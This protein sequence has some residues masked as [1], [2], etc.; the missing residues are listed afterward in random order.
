MKVFHCDHCD[1]L[2]FFENTHCIACGNRLAYLPE[3]SRIG[4]LD[5]AEELQW[6]CPASDAEG[7]RWRLCA[8]YTEHDVCNWAVAADDPELLCLSCRLT[9]VIPDLDKPNQKLWW[10]RLEM[11]KRRLLYALLALKLPVRSKEEDPD[12]GVAFEFRA[13]PEDPEEPPVLTGHAAGVITINVAEADDAERER[14]RVLLHEPYR[15]LLGHVRHEV[16]HYFWDRLIR[17]DDDRLAGFR[18]LFGDER[19][20]YAEALK[21]HYDHGPAEDWPDRCVTA[22]ASVHPWEDWAETWAH[23]LHITDTVEIA[24][25]SGL[26]LRPRQRNRL[27]LASVPDPVAGEAAGFDRMMESWY[28]LTYI[29]NNL[30]RGLGLP[31]AYPFV[32]PGPAIEKLRF[33]HDVIG[34]A[35]RSCPYHVDRPDSGLVIVNAVRWL[36][37]GFQVISMETPASRI[38]S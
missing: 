1:Q 14:R 17:D 29:L 24:A 35:S 25:D 34:E 22:Y 27:R 6:Q 13:D 12:G 33:I 3:L 9:Q 23:Y 4:S 31:V 26:T 18:A 7:R 15:T 32:L 10:Y 30:N 16:G 38:P 5:P 20:D 11:A 36:L 21:S 8:N 19:Q 2:V 37:R 28:P